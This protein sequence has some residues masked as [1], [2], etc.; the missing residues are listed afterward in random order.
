MYNGVTRG[1]IELLIEIY[2]SLSFQDIFSI[3]SDFKCKF[4]TLRNE[5]S[6]LLGNL[7]IRDITSIFILYSG[8]KPRDVVKAVNIGKSEYSGLRNSIMARLKVKASNNDNNKHNVKKPLMVPETS[9]ETI[10]F[11]NRIYNV[12]MRNNIDTVEELKGLL[13]LGNE[14]ESI[15]RLR[16]LN[17]MGGKIAKEIYDGV[18]K[19]SNET[20]D[21][22]SIKIDVSA[23]RKQLDDL[24]S[25]ISKIDSIDDATILY[26]NLISR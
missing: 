25:R 8:L 20:E 21:T 3:K 14:E 12:L 5:L 23:K 22:P 16:Q 6:S 17:G 2:T 11:S 10:G 7:D 4:D 18:M 19:M 9:I 24:I 26:N 15:G 13:V 1:D